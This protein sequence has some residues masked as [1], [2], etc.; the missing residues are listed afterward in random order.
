M[1]KNSILATLLCIIFAST[2]F[3]MEPENVN[4]SW[5]TLVTNSLLYGTHYPEKSFFQDPAFDLLSLEEQAEIFEFLN[6]NNIASTLESTAHTI[7]LLAKVNEQLDTLI[8]NPKFCLTLIKRLAFRFDCSNETVAIALQTKEAKK[9]LAIQKKF[10]ILF[11]QSNY[12]A[13]LIGLTKP[14]LYDFS[15]ETFEKLYDKYKNYV[16]LNFTYRNFK[17]PFY[18]D[19]DTLL[20][21]S[22]MYPS[23]YKTDKIASLLETHKVNINYQNAEEDSAL[24]KCAQNCDNP[25][26]LKLLCDD[27]NTVIDLSGKDN[28]TALITVCLM[29]QKNQKAICIALL[30]RAGADPEKMNGYGRT[31]LFILEHMG[32]NEKEIKLIKDAIQKKHAQAPYFAKGYE[33]QAKKRVNKK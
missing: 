6:K 22:A 3:G 14:I 15:I 1:K 18:D 12:L 32:D 11:S 5:L 33:G 7:N 2:S 9:R 10:E 19:K 24:I 8:N 13:P 21:N 28:K 23:P 31:P 29:K 27:P 16:D 25:A 17:E 30:L 4:P 20:I 26:A